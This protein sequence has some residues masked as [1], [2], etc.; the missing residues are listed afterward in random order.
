MK[1]D[2]LQDVERRQLKLARRWLRQWAKDWLTDHEEAKDVEV[3]IGGSNP[4]NTEKGWRVYVFSHS[5]A[6]GSSARHWQVAAAE[7]VREHAHHVFVGKE[8]GA[9]WTFT[10]DGRLV[11]NKLARGAR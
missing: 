3:V 4:Y 8:I 7:L 11:T 9:R 6:Q 10:R 2:A 5:S 1:S